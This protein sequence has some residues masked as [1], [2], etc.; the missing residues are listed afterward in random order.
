[1]PVD[2]P[3]HPFSAALTLVVHD[4]YELRVVCDE[5]YMRPD[6]PTDDAQVV[7]RFLRF[8]GF[9]EAVSNFFKGSIDGRSPQFGFVA[10]VV[11][12]ES[13]RHA[14]ACRDFARGRPV[15]TLLCESG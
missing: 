3:P 11:A 14:G 4:A 8:H 10:E 2:E 5:T 13:L 9:V 7:V 12:Q 1:M 6:S 15:E